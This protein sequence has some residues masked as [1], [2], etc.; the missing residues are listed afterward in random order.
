LLEAH[1]GHVVF[2][3]KKSGTVMVS[4]SVGAGVEGG[5]A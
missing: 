1:P 2:V 4:T 5:A 3:G